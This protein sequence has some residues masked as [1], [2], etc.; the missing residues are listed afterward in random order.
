MNTRL[1]I[2]CSESNDTVVD[3]EDATVSCLIQA[4][5]LFYFSENTNA[6]LQVELYGEW[7]PVAEQGVAPDLW[8]KAGEG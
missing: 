7:R 8:F 2:G 4:I 5:R 1:M 6:N 3:H